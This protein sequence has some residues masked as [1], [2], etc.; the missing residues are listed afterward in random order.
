MDL[1]Y[2][3]PYY[4]A[5]KKNEDSEKNLGKCGWAA[6]IVA[7][8]LAIASVVV[9]IVPI[10][11]V[12]TTPGPTFDLNAPFHG[13]ELIS[14][15]GTDPHTGQAVTADRPHDGQLRM[16]TVSEY[17]GPGHPITTFDLLRLTWDGVSEVDHYY[18]IYNDEVTAD[19][20][21][22]FAQAMMTSSHSTSSVAALEQLGYDVPAVV[23]VTGAVE[24]SHAE[25]KVEAGDILVSVTDHSGTVH[26]VNRAGTIFAVMAKTP[27]DS[28]VTLVVKRHGVDIP[29]SIVSTAAPDGIGSKLGIY[30]DIKTTLPFDV[31]FNIED[32]GGPSA[33][34]M[35]AL[36]IID[37][38]TEGD[39]TGGKPVAGTGAL[40]YDG[41]VEPIGGLPQKMVGAYNEGARYFL[42]PDV[43]CDEVTS[44]PEGL[45]VFRVADL[46]EAVSAV[47]AIKA[48]DTSALRPCVAK[49]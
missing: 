10:P 8:L 34:M 32:I 14:V 9:F 23:S 11:Y 1:E 42:A 41:R 19:Q 3:R 39:L 18:D 47:E 7:F 35:F 43:N 20:V 36:A 40:H 29:L 21:Q 4:M 16:V 15:N 37:K 49:P 22:S 27:A 38:L 28:T 24:G 13:H 48:G 33:G 31:T 25:G 30:L 2:T 26:P 12:V 45:E 5:P 44:T 17:G 46:N 6:L